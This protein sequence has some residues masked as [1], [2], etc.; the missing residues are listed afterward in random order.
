MEDPC[1]NALLIVSERALAAMARELGTDDATHTTRADELTG[2]L[3]ARLWDDTAG[4]FRAR[5]LSTDTLVDER[6]VTGLIPLVVPGLPHDIVGRLQDTLDGPHFSAP[7]TRLVP[8]YDLTGHAFDAQRYW[9]GPAWFNTAWLIH[10]GLH[11]HGLHTDAE[12][13]QQ[14]LLTEAG[15]SRF[16]EYVDPTTGGGR[17]T[18]HFSWTAALAL[19]LLR[20]DPKEPQP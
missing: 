8:S 4:L 18:R 5:D 15:R 3:V 16:A 6:S 20:A 13:L 12:R 14:G 1:F 11:T 9:R 17:G 19:D 10:R 7:A 2:Q